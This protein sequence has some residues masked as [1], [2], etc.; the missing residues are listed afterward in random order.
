MEAFRWDPAYATGFGEIDEQHRVLVALINRFA[1]HAEGRPNLRESSA[2]EALTSLGEYA[3]L[4]FASEE[5]LAQSAGVD[6]GTRTAHADLHRGFRIGVDQMRQEGAAPA[7]VL[8][9]LVHWLAHHILH[10]DHSLAREIR[11]VQRGTAPHDARANEQRRME[12]SVGP[13]LR[14]VSG[15]FQLLAER[16]NALLLAKNELEARVEARTAAL[17][18]AN[19]QLE[20]LAATDALTQL[21]NRR[22]ALARLEQEWASGGV[23]SLV[24]LDVD[25]FKAVNDTWGHD[26]GDRLLRACARSLAGSIRTDDVA[27]R[28]GG[29]EF[30]ILC[31]S[32]T[33]EGALAFAE[34]VRQAVA[35]TA[36]PAGDGALTVSVSIGTAT[37]AA[38]TAGAAAL[39]IEADRALYVAKRDGKNR[40]WQSTS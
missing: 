19:A 10:A 23:L 38:A 26:A 15:L 2:A 21:P 6:S 11:D 33:A 1:E 39:L 27:A 18:A 25:D 22:A 12:S 24:L 32:T 13:L 31:P 5:R 3:E 8:Q 28:L 40:I 37:R 16:N 34:A 7:Q 4:H 35:Q 9:F 29:D 17:R 20:R 14:A 30:L 36:M